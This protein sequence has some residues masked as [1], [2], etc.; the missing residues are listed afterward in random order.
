[1]STITKI[2][3]PGSTTQYDIGVEWENIAGGSEKLQAEIN[4][5]IESMTGLDGKEDKAN[6]VT[7]LS[8]NS[9]DTEYPSAKLVY[10]QLSEKAN[11]ATTLSGYGI[12]NA[13]TRTQVNN[14]NVSTFNNDA[15]YL[16]E[17]QQL[18]HIPSALSELINDSNFISSDTANS[19]YIKRIQVEND[20][21]DIADDS[22]A[23]Y[24]HILHGS[25]EGL[26][27]FMGYQNY[28]ADSLA[29]VTQI[30][31]SRTR[32]LEYRIGVVMG[33]RIYQWDCAAGA[34]WHP[35]IATSEKG[36]LAFPN[37]YAWYTE[38]R[39]DR[40]SLQITLNYQ[41][42][43][44]LVTVT[45]IAPLVSGFVTTHYSLPIAPA[46]S[47]GTIARYNNE[48]YAITIGE[49]NNTSILSIEN[50]NHNAAPIGSIKFSLT[51]KKA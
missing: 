49:L 40:E 1:M 36:N 35:Y 51:Y 47:G 2:Q 6:K 19:N 27:F 42:D 50:V 20:N 4:R 32:G 28:S 31:M 29:R 46:Q 30:R 18:P 37:R 43:G 24:T 33:Y 39:E 13:Y 8:E 7:S 12:T 9:T 38:N 5:A 22:N 14:L 15:G 23:I 34:S 45:A 3:L 16:T 41:I 11:K 21:L 26:V 10:N 25:F 44:D 17:H 48:F